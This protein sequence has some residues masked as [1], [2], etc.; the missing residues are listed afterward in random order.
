MTPWPSLSDSAVSK[1]VLP[2]AEQGSFFHVRVAA[3]YPA[4]PNGK[5]ITFHCQGDDGRIYFCKDDTGARPVRATE[6]IATNLAKH[7]GISV[8]NCVIIEE[9]D[10][11]FFGSQSPRSVATD[12]A[13][14]D[15]IEKS[16]RNEL[17]QPE[18]WIGRYFSQVWAFDL[19]IDNPDR[20]LRNFILDLDGS[21]AQ[22]RAI[23]FADASVLEFSVD[24]FPV[25]SAS[26][27]RIGRIVRKRHGTHRA[28]AFEIL[29]RLRAVPL[30][31]IEDI[32]KGMP[33]S[34]LSRDQAG[35]LLEVWSDGRIE[36]RLSRTKALIEHEWED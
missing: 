36:Q 3:R 29:D 15:H 32:L 17:G 26:T 27:S 18:P 34:W 2:L 16:A 35:G 1:G 25:A 8:G 7:L 33:E 9:D 10:R 30:S 13:L 12:F 19:F 28:A 11:S 4:F 5:D 23:D 31:V 24:K 14:Q 22:V 20:H 6:W 21:T